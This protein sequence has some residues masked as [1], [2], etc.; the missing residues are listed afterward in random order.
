MGLYGAA[1]YWVDGLRPRVAHA[2]CTHSFTIQ[3]VERLLSVLNEKFGLKC[4]IHRNRGKHVIYIRARSMPVFRAI[5]SATPPPFHPFNAL[6][7]PCVYTGLR[8]ACAETC[9]GRF[10]GPPPAGPQRSTMVERQGKGALARRRPR[11]RSVTPSICGESREEL[12]NPQESFICY[13]SETLRR[14]SC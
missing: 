1:A 14:A 4:S 2:L 8:C 12:G 5:V 11:E 7:W 3:E 13:S 6:A 9:L 10:C